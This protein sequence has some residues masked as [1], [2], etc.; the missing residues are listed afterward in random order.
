MKYILLL[1]FPV[2]AF[3]QTDII[4]NG[5]H[6]NELDANNQ[7][8]GIW[9]VFDNTK[10]LVA[11]CEFKGGLPISPTRYY[12][13][14]KLILSVTDEICVVYRQHDSILAKKVNANTVFD[15]LVD[16]N[17][18]ELAPELVNVYNSN[19]SI[20]PM[21]YGGIPA[22]TEYLKYNIDRKKTRGRKGQVKVKFNIDKNG[23][24]E[25]VEITSSSDPLLN[26]EAIRLIKDMPRWQPGV[27]NGRFVRIQYNLPLTFN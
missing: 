15:K 16:S 26:D 21:C 5:E 4:Y 25:N 22:L 20:Q 14:T 24:T 18:N 11:T 23:F 2:F 10:N 3:A 17:G 19:N 1:L 8:T 9:K 12:K 6:I 13:D 27:Q 7:K